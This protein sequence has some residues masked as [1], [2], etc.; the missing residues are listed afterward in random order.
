[1]AS[2]NTKSPLLKISN[3]KVCFPVRGG[4][5]K[6]VNGVDFSIAENEVF[7]IVGESGSGK[8]ITAFS[9]V[10]LLPPPGRVVEGQILFKGNDLLQFPLRKMRKIRGAQI[11]MIFQ[12]PM[13]ALNPLLTIGSQITEAIRAHQN[14]KSMEA[15][16]RVCG[17]LEQVGI[18]DPKACYN[19]YP[20]QFSGGQR[21][22]IMIAVALVCKPSLLI[23]D[24]PTTALDVTTQVQI[25]DLI[26]TMQK[27]IKTS[28]ILITHDLGII[29]EFAHRVAVMYAGTLMELADVYSLFDYPRHP[30]TR[31]L[32]RAIPYVQGQKD[33]QRLNEIPGMIPS[34][35]N[36]P[37]GCKFHPRCR[38]AEPICSK[39]EPPL[40]FIDE[41]HLAKCW[42]A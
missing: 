7:G 18:A 26:E 21:Q 14:V 20:H 29:A 24:E 23:A 32:M 35:L 40:M 28:V 30:Y 8:T 22:R 39:D 19:K 2:L 34:L 3:L 16:E 12:E 38:R 41:G 17:I 31:A 1:M 9:V 13:S 4:T 37:Q 25:L 42:F 33:N 15:R 5:I 6:A 11:S 10:R 27:E 36:L